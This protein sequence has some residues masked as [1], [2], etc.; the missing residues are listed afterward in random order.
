MSGISRISIPSL[1][2]TEPRQR[3]A[4][5]LG[6]ANE[7]SNQSNASF[8]SAVHLLTTNQS[9][10]RVNSAGCSRNMSR[11]QPGSV[12]VSP[13]AA[14][15]ERLNISALAFGQKTIGKIV[16]FP[17]EE[18]S[19]IF[20]NLCPLINTNVSPQEFNAPTLRKIAWGLAEL[21]ALFK[22]ASNSDIED[23]LE[24]VP[25]LK[26]YINTY[27][28]TSE[29]I[30][31]L[32]KAGFSNF[33]SMGKKAINRPAGKSLSATR[34]QEVLRRQMS[35]PYQLDQPSYSSASTVNM[36]P[37]YCQQQFDSSGTRRQERHA[38][39]L[40]ETKEVDLFR[41]PVTR[42]SFDASTLVRRGGMTPLRGLERG[43]VSFEDRKENAEKK[44]HALS[45]YQKNGLTY[46][47]PRN[48]ISRMIESLSPLITQRTSFLDADSSSKL[49]AALGL[50]W[51]GV[52]KACNRRQYFLAWIKEFPALET[53]IKITG[54][55]KAG[56]KLLAEGV[57]APNRVKI[58]NNNS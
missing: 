9:L 14:D 4:S 45:M 13:S 39:Y 55:T 8:M 50:V 53:Y 22:R 26:G 49:G 10:S 5:A 46:L 29:G 20:E 16:Q 15:R 32:S 23:L 24:K 7:K 36:R 35:H 30:S 40:G 44:L 28:L 3:E 21:L 27:G 18:L 38:G 54:L 48:E 31:L 12:Q 34:G 58:Q 33:S 47:L 17:Y 1:L 51:Q 42:N 6:V 41:A 25:P 57:C 56:E 52:E 11:H 37:Q 43:L 19:P 2:I